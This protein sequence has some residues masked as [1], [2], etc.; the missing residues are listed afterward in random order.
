[1]NFRLQ[2]FRMGTIIFEAAVKAHCYVW[3]QFLDVLDD[4]ILSDLREPC[5]LQGQIP[6]S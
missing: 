1:M 5:T 2:E 3:L 4:Y 6:F